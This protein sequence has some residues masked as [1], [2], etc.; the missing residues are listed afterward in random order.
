MNSV[1]AVSSRN[2]G[3]SV[4]VCPGVLRRQMSLVGSDSLAP[5]SMPA[6]SVCN[7]T[8]NNIHVN[9]H[10]SI[11]TLLYV[12]LPVHSC[13]S[14]CMQCALM[15]LKSMQ[16]FRIKWTSELQH[17]MHHHSL[18]AWLSLL[19]DVLKRP[20]H[21]THN[22]W[23]LCVRVRTIPVLGYWVLANTCQYWVVLVLAQY[24]S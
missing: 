15:L 22:K 13:E 5:A 8:V 24:F 4:S 12:S 19:T 1:T 10:L 7:P 16:G 14:T 9:G 18:V 3:L 20:L 23:L 6:W 11:K 21:K 2:L 17:C